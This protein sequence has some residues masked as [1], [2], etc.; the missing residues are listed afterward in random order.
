MLPSSRKWKRPKYSVRPQRRWQ[1]RNRCG[2]RTY[3]RLFPDVSPPFPGAKTIYLSA[4]DATSNTGFI[5]QGSFT[6]SIPVGQPTADSVSPNTGLGATQTFNFVYSDTVF[7]SNLTAVAF[8][9]NTSTAL[10][11]TCYV[12]Y[13][14]TANTIALITDNGL[15]SSSK[16]ISS[17]TVLQNSQCQVGIT[18]SAQSGLS[19]ILTVSITFKGAFSGLK[20]IYL[21]A[22]AGSLNTGWVQRGTFTAANGGVPVSVSA[23][24]G[25]GSGPGQRFSFIISDQAGPVI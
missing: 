23:V 24:P 6:V 7:A 5:A 20:N 9:F 18:S 12:V 19:V 15:S 10:T 2:E 14:L 8:L 3:R 13:D 22:S 25:T 21:S 11:N 17:T 1:F 4:A 16:P